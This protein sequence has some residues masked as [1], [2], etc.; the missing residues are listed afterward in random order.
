[1]THV[2]YSVQVSKSTQRLIE[3]LRA[4]MNSL[5]QLSRS[6]LAS[7]L[8][9][10]V[11]GIALALPLSLFVVLKN[12]QIVSDSFQT[13]GQINLY[14]QNNISPDQLHNTLL[15]LNMDQNVVKSQYIS[16]QQGFQEFSENA[17]LTNSNLN[18]NNN[19]LPGVI[20]VTPSPELNTL[21]V[22][23]LVSRL[24]KLPSVTTAQLDLKWLQR[25][26]AILAIGHRAA[27]LLMVIFAI[28]V[29]LIIANTIRLTTQN[30]HDEILV[31][32]LIGGANSFIRRPFLYSGIVY[33]LIGAIFA[34]LLVDMMIS[35]L[36][37]PISKLASLYGTTYE[38]QGLGLQ[39]T[40]Y[41]VVGG[42]LLG[43]IAS[44][45]AVSRYIHEI[46]PS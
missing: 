9:F 28:A 22:E 31:I 45:I 26:N 12:V 38:I 18:L 35:F 14:L 1:M 41:L 6:P 46:E 39:T 23:Q 29:L 2:N 19:P 20:V 17:G 10:A 30:H 25:L 32:K 34:W 43:L 44:W 21:Q 36:Q 13:T 15:V 8:T 27:V 40:L 33:G 11:I 4:I 16:P 3:H 7:L 24:A 42:I 5:G 37:N